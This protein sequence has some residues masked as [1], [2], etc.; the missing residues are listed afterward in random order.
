MDGIAAAAEINAAHPELPVVMLTVSTFD[1]D[2]F[3]SLRVGAVGFLSKGLLPHVLLRTLRDYRLHGALPMSRQ[4]AAKMLRYFRRQI[5]F[6]R[7]ATAVTALSERERQVLTMVARGAHDREIAA[8]LQLGETTIKSHVHNALR[9][10][11]ARN[12]A[13]A[14]ALFRWAAPD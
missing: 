10:L 7:R 9:K 13:E 8:A 2:L 11:H 14:A 6:G 12:R 5:V 3:E 1:S 4:M